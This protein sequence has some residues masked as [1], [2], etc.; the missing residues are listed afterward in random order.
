[1][2]CSFLRTTESPHLI[3]RTNPDSLQNRSLQSNQAYSIAIREKKGNERMNDQP[4]IRVETAEDEPKATRSARRWMAA[5]ILSLALGALLVSGTAF[6]Q[7]D[8]EDPTLHQS[9]LDRLAGKLGLSSSDLEATIRETQ[10]E[11]VDDA[12]ANG[13]LTEQQGNALKERIASGDGIVRFMPGQHKIVRHA[14]GILDINLETVA[15]QLG[16]TGDDLRSELEG[17]ATLTEVITAQGSTVEAVVEGLVADAETTLDDAVANGTLT[18][19]QADRIL[20]NL[21]E[22]LTRMIES[23]LSGDCDRWFHDN[24]GAD[25]DVNAEETS[26]QV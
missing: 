10:V 24:D 16:M 11:A 2:P 5:G 19:A 20:T 17:G 1:M 22:R 23:G 26:S 18:Q 15:A 8:T 7:S 14:F 4:P 25:D 6:A 21:P 3:F 13:S 12:V 9:V